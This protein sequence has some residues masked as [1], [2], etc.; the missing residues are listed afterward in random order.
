M[1]A[2]RKVGDGG[3]PLRYK[4]FMNLISMEIPHI[5]ELPLFSI[6]VL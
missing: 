5:P 4:A 6:N 3:Y 1:Y 2:K